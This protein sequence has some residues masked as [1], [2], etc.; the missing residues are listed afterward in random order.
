MLSVGTGTSS[1]GTIKDEDH[2]TKTSASC[3]NCN[4]SLTIVFPIKRFNLS[5]RQLLISSDISETLGYVRPLI[6]I[7]VS[8]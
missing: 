5:D 8:I 3:G 1:S 4:S 6:G 7:N 2:N